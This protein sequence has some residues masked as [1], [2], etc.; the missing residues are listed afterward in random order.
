MKRLALEKKVGHLQRN[1][2]FFVYYVTA[3][4]DVLG[5]LELRSMGMVFQPLNPRFKGT[6]S[7]QTGDLN[8]NCHAGF[9]LLYKD[10]HDTTTIVPVPSQEPGESEEDDHPLVFH[11]QVGLKHTGKYPKLS[12]KE[13]Q[14][15]HKLADS[16][17]PIASL[18][19]KG[20][21]ASLD[22]KL[23]PNEERK[24]YVKLFQTRL[25]EI[26][27]RLDPEDLQI[28][29]DIADLEDPDDDIMEESP[30]PLRKREQS[31]SLKGHNTSIPFFDLNFRGLFPGPQQPTYTRV[32]SEFELL[33]NLF[34]FKCR[35]LEDVS[36]ES[37]VSLKHLFPEV[38]LVRQQRI[39]SSEQ[40]VTVVE[41]STLDLMEKSK[42]EQRKKEASKILYWDSDKNQVCEHE[43]LESE[44]SISKDSTEKPAA[45]LFFSNSEIMFKNSQLLVVYFL[46]S[47]RPLC[48]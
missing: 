3:Q 21:I 48:T 20:R 5:T 2:I 44:F 14:L 42:R 32:Q 35:A 47:A 18:D 13:K 34:G 43:G 7:Y 23:W 12:Q 45:A 46:T 25:N 10:L 8:D 26:R 39:Q 38:E 30:S 6:F 37:F 31:L 29:A 17:T 9:I 40:S 28:S 27:A 15:V 1:P 22:G 33:Q 41:L 24:N 36:N 16:K 4:G 11:L 19:L